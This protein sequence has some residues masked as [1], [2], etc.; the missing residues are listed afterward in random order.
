MSLPFLF[1]WYSIQSKSS[2]TKGQFCRN[3]NLNRRQEA[4]PQLEPTAGPSPA[5]IVFHDVAQA[6]PSN[7]GNDACNLYVQDIGNQETSAGTTRA[8]STLFV[9]SE[10]NERR[11]NERKDQNSGANAPPRWPSTAPPSTQAF[12]GYEIISHEL[13]F[14]EHLSASKRQVLE[15]AVSFIN[16]LSQNPTVQSAPAQRHTR[17]ETIN[18]IAIPSTEFLYWMIR[19]MSQIYKSPILMAILMPI[20]SLDRYRKQKVRFLRFRL[21]QTCLSGVSEEDGSLAAAQGN[22]WRWFPSF[23][24]MRKFYRF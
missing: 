24:N 9:D 22:Q 7:P 3:N 16:Q 10:R 19:G 5:D 6:S 23:F 12:E 21:F 1:L 2:L 4:V 17:E 8:P 15:S 20:P 14:R 13:Q 11:H 18:G